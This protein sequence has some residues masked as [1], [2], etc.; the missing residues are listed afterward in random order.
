MTKKMPKTQRMN[1][2]IQA[3]LDEFLNKGYEGASMEGIARKARIS[4]GGLYHHFKSKDEILLFANQKFDEPINKI[5]MQASGKT[6][7]ENGLIYYVE[8]YLKYWK[9]HQRE[10]VFYSLSMTKVLDSPDLWQMY[11]AYIE[12]Y[13]AFIQALFQHGIDTGE[14]SDHSARESA[15]TLIAALD[16]IVFYLMIDKKLKL[17]EIVLMFQKKFISQLKV[18]HK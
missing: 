3:A 5:R 4:K 1:Q 12:K 13:I 9:R 8:Q 14:F 10:I 16:G 7:A 11:E 17:E 6:S 2:I 15:I 18:K